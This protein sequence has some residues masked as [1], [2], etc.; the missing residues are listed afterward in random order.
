[1][2]LL[3]GGLFLVRR[4]YAGNLAGGKPLTH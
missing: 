3:I 4:D 2:L 1:V